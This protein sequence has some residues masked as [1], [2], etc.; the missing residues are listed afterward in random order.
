[1]FKSVS[2]NMF[3]NFYQVFIEFKIYLKFKWIKYLNE[4]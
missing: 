2:F 3:G 4:S 1:M